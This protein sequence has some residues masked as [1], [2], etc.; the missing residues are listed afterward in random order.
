MESVRGAVG[1]DYPVLVKLSGNDY[2]DGGLTTTE[3]LHVAR[4]LVQDGIDCIEVSA[5]SRASANGMVA[6]RTNIAREGDEGYLADLAGLFKENVP[7]P[8]VTV[9]GIRSLSVISRILA[10]GLADYVA[11]SRPLVREPDLIK[12]WNSGRVEK[13]NCVSCN[14]CYDTGLQGLGISCKIE[15]KKQERS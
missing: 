4:R 1:K 8:I 6:S 7:V 11:L 15:R 9:G 10:D 3:S 5:G 14:G 13:S 2:L 12:R